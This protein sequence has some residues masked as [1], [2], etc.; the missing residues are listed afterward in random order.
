MWKLTLGYGSQQGKSNKFPF[1]DIHCNTSWCILPIFASLRIF[2]TPLTSIISTQFTSK[3][4]SLILSWMDGSYCLVW[5]IDLIFYLC[6]EWTQHRF[7]NNYIQIKCICQRNGMSY[8]YHSC[9]LANLI[10][11]WASSMNGQ[12]SHHPLSSNWCWWMYIIMIIKLIIH[13]WYMHPWMFISSIMGKKNASTTMVASFLWQFNWVSRG[14]YFVFLFIPYLQFI[15]INGHL[16]VAL[17][18]FGYIMGCS[19]GTSS[20]MK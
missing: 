16:R 2:Q 14:A 20:R 8:E 12:L 17:C 15:I 6:H 1:L 3:W 11:G 18:C 4:Y 5:K 10:H 9:N 19:K 7:R 13:W